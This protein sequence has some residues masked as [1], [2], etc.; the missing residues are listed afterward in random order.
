[1]KLS[2]RHDVDWFNPIC[3]QY[4]FQPGEEY[5][6]GMC[7]TTGN[8]QGHYDP[9]MNGPSSGPNYFCDPDTNITGCEVGDLTGKH[10]RIDVGGTTK[11]CL[12]LWYCGTA[13]M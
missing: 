1:M 6:V 3:S 9:F 11:L 8:L 12:F 7:D 2:H 4:L 5:R 13:T 10:A